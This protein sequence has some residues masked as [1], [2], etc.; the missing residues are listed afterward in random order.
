M[1]GDENT[2][3]TLTLDV[4]LPYQIVREERSRLCVWIFQRMNYFVKVCQAAFFSRKYGIP[5]W[6]PEKFSAITVAAF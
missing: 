1:T 5:I 4:S 2:A 3:L 6:S